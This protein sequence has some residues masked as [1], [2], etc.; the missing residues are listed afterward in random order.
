M[1]QLTEVD[2]L[3]DET[4][5]FRLSLFGMSIYENWISLC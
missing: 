1:S 4:R 2:V 3:V 5:D